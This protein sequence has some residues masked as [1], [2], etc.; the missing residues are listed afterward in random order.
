MHSWYNPRFFTFDQFAFLCLST[1]LTT[2]ITTDGDFSFAFRVLVFPK[3]EK[4]KIKQELKKLGIAESR[5]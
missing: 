3:E 2:I 5:V 4:K 1:L